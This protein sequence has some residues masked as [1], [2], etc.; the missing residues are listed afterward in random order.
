MA[1]FFEA[2][3]GEIIPAWQNLTKALV[4]FWGV[5]EVYLAEWIGEPLL[6]L[7][8]QEVFDGANDATSDAIEGA[9]NSFWNFFIN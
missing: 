8:N 7:F 9:G 2:L 4:G 3:F 1:S 5:I 6:R